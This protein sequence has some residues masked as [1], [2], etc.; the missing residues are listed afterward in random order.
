MQACDN[1]IYC[2]PPKQ[3]ICPKLYKQFSCGIYIPWIDQGAVVIGEGNVGDELSAIGCSI[4]SSSSNCISECRQVYIAEI[5]DWHAC[6]SRM[7]GG[8][9]LSRSKWIIGHWRGERGFCNRWTESDSCF[10]FCTSY[11]WSIEF[12]TDTPRNIL[13]VVYPDM[14]DRSGFLCFFMCFLFIEF[15]LEVGVWFSFCGCTIR[16]RLA[17]ANIV[18]IARP[19]ETITYSWKSCIDLLSDLIWLSCLEV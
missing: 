1:C 9:C 5:E 13:L 6:S 3:K 4:I 14:H 17:F 10:G 18:A 15:V 7:V 12:S 11:P 16:T 8:H 19:V 2:S